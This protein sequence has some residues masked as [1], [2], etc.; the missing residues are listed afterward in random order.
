[1]SC[2]QLKEATIKHGQKP[3]L[4]SSKVHRINYVCTFVLLVEHGAAEELSNEQSI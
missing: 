2:L 4:D 1:M 3:L